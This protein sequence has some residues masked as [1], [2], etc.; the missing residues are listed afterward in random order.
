MRPQLPRA[1]ARPQLHVAYLYGLPSCASKA[2]SMFLPQRNIPFDTDSLFNKTETKNYPL[3]ILNAQR[4][5]NDNQKGTVC[6]SAGGN[7]VGVL[8][9][10]LWQLRLSKPFA[11]FRG[12]KV[13]HKKGY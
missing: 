3:P 2:L 12:A 9:S 7:E 6:R 11:H 8:H 10:L 4:N 13:V 5:P 1:D